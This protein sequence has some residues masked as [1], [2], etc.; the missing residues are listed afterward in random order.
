MQNEAESGFHQLEIAPTLAIIERLQSDRTYRDTRGLFFVEGVRN[1]IE[2]VDHRFPVDTLLYSE[3]LLINPIARKLVRRLKRAGV[4]FARVTPEQFRRV[5][6]T[7]RASGVAAI[8]RQIILRLEQI[9]LEDQQCWSALSHVRSPGNF[10]TLLRTSA[11]TGASGF[12]LLGDRIDPFDPAVVRATM[13]ALF[14]QTLVRTSVEQL[15]RWVRMHSIQV[16][17]ASPDGQVGYNEVSYTRPAVLMLGSERK[18]LT[19]EQ[20]SM[21]NRIV[22]IPMVEGMDSLNVAVAG[23]LLMYEM[24][25]SSS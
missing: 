10:G 4:P 24:F 18:G 7:E 3:K 8:L 25:R 11:A 23:S 9:K 22:R 1:F 12:I 20:R 5:S 2:A 15:R 16:T 19:D 17:G 21:C 14:K 6:R 13:G